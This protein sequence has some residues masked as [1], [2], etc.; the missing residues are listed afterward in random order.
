[1]LVFPSGISRGVVY[2]YDKNARNVYLNRTNATQYLTGEHFYG[3]GRSWSGLRNVSIA[4]DNSEGAF[5]YQDDIP[6]EEYTKNGDVKVH[7]QAV[8]F[9]EEFM[10]CIGEILIDNGV[11]VAQQDRSIFGLSYVTHPCESFEGLNYDYEIHIIYG[12]TAGVTQRQFITEADNSTV[13]AYNWDCDTV[14]EPFSDPLKIPSA[15]IVIRVRNDKDQ[16]YLD[17]IAFLESCL[18]G[19]ENTEPFL[20]MP[21]DII[22][23]IE[24]Y[25]EEFLLNLDNAINFVL[26]T[27][28]NCGIVGNVY[29]VEDAIVNFN[30]N[31]E[32]FGELVKFNRLL[33]DHICNF[34][35]TNSISGVRINFHGK[36][37]DNITTLEFSNEIVDSLIRVYDEII[38]ST[39]QF[40]FSE[41]IFD[42]LVAIREHASNTA[43]HFVFQNEI[44]GSRVS[45]EPNSLITVQQFTFTNSIYGR[46]IRTFTTGINDSFTIAFTNEIYDALISIK[47]QEMVFSC[48]LSFS[49]EIYCERIRSNNLILNAIEGFV[50]Q[51]E[52]SDRLIHVYDETV[53][54]IAAFVFSE[55]F[56]NVRLHINEHIVNHLI[57]FALS[58]NQVS[59]RLHINPEE[60]LSIEIFTISA[61]AYGKLIRTI[62]AFVEETVNFISE[63]DAYGYRPN[64][65]YTG[66]IGTVN[67][68]TVSDGTG[69]KP[70]PKDKLVNFTTVFVY[71][72]EIVG[73]LREAWSYPVED[74]FLKIIWHYSASVSG[75]WLLIV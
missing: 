21:D 45:I 51:N 57:V 26:D 63:S 6:I 72:N 48:L 8:N 17:K 71:T 29:P 50:W 22:E 73:R 75:G 20:P 43:L 37:I 5:S 11:S 38:N 18:Y 27:I 42:S 33:V 30:S 55:E 40:T 59:E 15:E 34:V 47:S 44:N 67:F 66:Q 68:V 28:S 41:E 70:N 58:E 13:L 61:E 14:P 46:L 49:E 1:M 32:I 65:V 54:H 19:T 74:G 64:P 7:I 35:F 10:P 53:N 23:D 12:M 36:I 4:I 39:E 56:Q 3:H 24:P 31:Y 9:P 60:V 25:P 16:G 52:I 69:Y 62:A 2:F